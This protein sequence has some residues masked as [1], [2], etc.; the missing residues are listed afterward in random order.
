VCANCGAAQ[1]KP[2]CGCRAPF[3]PGI[4][5]DPFLGSGTVGVAARRLGRD[6]LGIELNRDYV[7]LAAR[8]LGIQQPADPAAD[9]GEGE[10]PRP[11]ERGAPLETAA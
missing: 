3:V 9:P 11:H 4:V 5:L 10:P 2:G 6:W 1:P 8:R 7:L